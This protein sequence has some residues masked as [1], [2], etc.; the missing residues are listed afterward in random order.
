[1]FR[2]KDKE[3]SKAPWWVRFI[4]GLS[5]DEEEDHVYLNTLRNI[6]A[7]L[8]RLLLGVKSVG[9]NIGQIEARAVV[10]SIIVISFVLATCFLA[11]YAPQFVMIWINNMTPLVAGSIVWFFFGRHSKELSDYAKAVYRAFPVPTP[12]ATVIVKKS[13]EGKGE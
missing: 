8:K 11:V 2:K 3:I 6:F 9:M 10:T 12:P 4:L 5:D 1:M 7:R 13:E